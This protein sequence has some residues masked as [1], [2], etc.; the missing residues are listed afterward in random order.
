MIEYIKCDR[1]PQHDRLSDIKNKE[2]QKHPGKSQ[3]SPTR[4]QNHTGLRF[5]HDTNECQKMMK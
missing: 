2:I 4:I 3:K 1:G 5:I